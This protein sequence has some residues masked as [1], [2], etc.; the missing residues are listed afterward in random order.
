MGFLSNFRIF[1]G[2]GNPIN[3]RIE[4][5]VLI[6]PINLPRVSCGLPSTQT[7]YMLEKVWSNSNIV[8]DKPH[9]EAS[10]FF[11][12]SDE[13]RFFYYSVEGD[14]I[15]KSKTIPD[16]SSIVNISSPNI[17]NGYRV[18]PSPNTQ[19][20]IINI[21]F[22]SEHGGNFEG[23]LEMSWGG[24]K[25]IFE[26]YC[27]SEEQDDR[28]IH[29][30]HRFGE[31]IGVEEERI[32]I[33]TNIDNDV[34]DNKRLNEK[35]K[36]YLN[37][38]SELQPY[39]GTVRGFD[40]LLHYF[41]WKDIVEIKEYYYDSESD[42][43]RYFQL[44]ENNKDK[45]NL[46]KLKSFGIFYKLNDVDWNSVGD[47]GH[48]VTF[49]VTTLSSQEI[50]IK[51][52][53]LKRF[54]EKRNIGG[55]SKVLDIIGEQYN[56]TKLKIRNWNNKSEY[57]DI[58]KD[59]TPSIEV[60]E[61]TGYLEDIRSFQVLSCP[62]TPEDDIE[63]TIIGD[64]TQCTIVGL[65]SG[66][67]E[68]YVVDSPFLDIG[69]LLR[70]RNSSFDVSWED[71]DTSWNIIEAPQTPTWDNLGGLM[72]YEAKISI[73]N[74]KGFLY[75]SDL[76]I[77]SLNEVT[78]ILP[79]TGYYNVKIFLRGFDGRRA[80][81]N[82]EKAIYI[83]EKKIEL[84]SV[85]KIIDLDLQTWNKNFLSWNVLYG[86]WRQT[87]YDNTEFKISSAQIESGDF[88]IVKYVRSRSKNGHEAL[89]FVD[90]LSSSWEDNR[91]LKW[92]DV[93]Y[94]FPI[95]TNAIIRSLVGG[96]EIYIGGEIFEVSTDIASENFVAIAEDFS[97]QFP[98]NL[99]FIAR[100]DRIDL[101]FIDIVPKVV[102]ATS[103]FYIA[104]ENT[105]NVFFAEYNLNSFNS[106]IQGFGQWGFWDELDF[107]WNQA[108]VLYRTNSR[109]EPFN[110]DNA[111][112][113][114]NEL[115][116][117]N[118]LP[119][120]ISVSPSPIKGK[121]ICSVQLLQD[122]DVVDELE[123]LFVSKRFVETGKYSLKINLEDNE[124]NKYQQF[125]R[126]I[127]HVVDTDTFFDV[128]QR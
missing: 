29:L 105:D 96:S 40:I 93:E 41:G 63:E 100:R 34:E 44:N 69:S 15:T 53:Y 104:S 116:I 101:P 78:T 38:L 111:R 50:A 102:S 81:R 10:E 82:F 4:N 118:N 74:N 42:K 106:F 75:E 126:N 113:F 48:P 122:D 108:N 51:M 87:I 123:G 94:S 97:Q 26:C 17:A 110:T 27:E 3:T 30:L 91:W 6:I 24:G 92:D 83:A 120:F 23:K 39:F 77:S 32:F 47:F 60:L 86:N 117:P 16:I 68:K 59:L 80:V 9:I 43:L 56:F 13:E 67:P 127:I 28:L 5:G 99:Y 45:D 14:E 64:L 119:L 79:H 114:D 52:F 109:Q 103:D 46:V 98:N 95:V 88:D 71:I 33:E 1:N 25:I 35:R 49:P 128:I 7:I 73:R 31:T 85:F 61:S 22:L 11:E 2:S 112:S 65:T 90:Y 57:L 124:N 107:T 55:I 115:V 62:F 70:I 36:E 76:P 21:G 84:N 20:F 72:Y 37:V 125:R 19:P 12:T 58:S 89:S 18:Q 66:A 8:F 121:T 54:F